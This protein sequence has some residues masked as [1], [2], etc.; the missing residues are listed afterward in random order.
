LRF[1]GQADSAYADRVPILAALAAALFII[2]LAIVLM[3]LT[4]VQRYRV[5]TM[6]RAARGW[7]ATLNLAAIF[8]TIAVFLV[9]SAITAI[10]VPRAFSYALAGLLIGA[11]CGL[12]GL[13][14]TRWDASPD[15]LHY[16]PN[17]WLVLI[18]TLVVTA[19]VAYGFWRSWHAWQSGLHGGTWFVVS[20]VAGSLGAGAIV[21]G[22]YFVYW[23]G[24][25]RRL[26][27]HQRVFGIGGRSMPPSRGFARRVD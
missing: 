18:I 11:A 10:W 27:K 13:A 16:T 5:G 3:P 9:S 22:Y 4:L 2:L 7:V 25:R 15:S 21:L 23:V 12:L 1:G 6:R 26:K 19:R 17:R 24:V 14:L 8:I 20:G